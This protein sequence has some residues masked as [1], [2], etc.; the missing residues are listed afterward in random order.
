[1]LDKSVIT[2]VASGALMA[3]IL[4]PGLF[5]AGGWGF[6]WIIIIA[7]S[8]AV[9]EFVSLLKKAFKNREISPPMIFGWLI[10]C[11]FTTMFLMIATQP[12][13]IIVL[14]FTCTI[15]NDV[16]AYIF[17][18]TFGGAIFKKRPF[19][20]VSPSKTWEGVIAGVVVSVVIALSV[21]SRHQFANPDLATFIAFSGGIFAVIGDY[22]ES[23]FKRITL[24]KDSNDLVTNIPVVS[25]LEMLLGGRKGHGGYWDRLDSILFLSL[26]IEA[27]TSWS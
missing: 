10:A 1:M 12:L 6:R 13:E 15:T 24:V 11:S 8:I 25:Q 14:A 23:A 22:L 27:I 21:V 26:V 20:L 3:I 19:P 2:R 4:I 9:L 5:I 7:T 16:M 18:R 17:G